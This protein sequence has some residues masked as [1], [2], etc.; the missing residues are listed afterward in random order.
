MQRTFG[1]SSK[2]AQLAVRFFTYG[3]MTISTVVLTILAIY[4]AMGYRFN[5]NLVIEQGGVIEFRTEPGN[6]IITLDGQPIGKQ[7]PNRTFAQAGE[8][9]VTM[10]LSGYRDW[11]KK[12]TLQ[13]GQLLWLDYARFIP[14]SITTSPVREFANVYKTLASPNHAWFAIQ[15]DPAAA[16]LTLA[17][18]S[19]DRAPLFTTLTLPEAVFTKKDGVRGTLTLLEWDQSSRYLLLRHDLGDTHELIRLDRTDPAAAVNINKQFN[20]AAATAHFADNGGN[21]LVAH[22]G[23]SLRRL[24][25]GAGNISAP[26]AVGVQ[27]FSL[28]DTSVGFTAGRGN[29]QIIAFYKDGKETVVATTTPD[30]PAIVA[31]GEYARHDYLAYSIGSGG[32]VVRDPAGS[33]SSSTQFVLDM[34]AEWLQFSP[35]GRFVLGGSQTAWNGYDIETGHGFSTP[36]GFI[37]PPEWLDDFH[38]FS[39]SSM[40]RIAEFDGQNT[41]DITAVAPGF[42]AVLSPS[43]RSVFSVGKTSQSTFV[44][45]ASRLVN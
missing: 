13:P 30:K 5:N 15:E 12:I 6:A 2:K 26:F 21:I 37:R 44:L 23:D 43:E 8:H 7:T 36:G 20:V 45:Q 4:Y 17:D 31:V 34:T 14:Q 3:V 27:Q 11:S 42:T 41:H 29:E 33:Q 40:L 39:D 16:Q 35:K 22:I 28:Q 18:L 9:T 24:D 32:V 38:V 10:E 1:M 25:V 19:N